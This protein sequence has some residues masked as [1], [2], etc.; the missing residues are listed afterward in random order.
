MKITWKLLFNLYYIICLG[1]SVVIGLGLLFF[2]M[3]DYHF[4]FQWIPAFFALF[5]FIGC[6]LLILIA[7][8]MGHWLAQSEG[9]YEK[10]RRR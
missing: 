10:R 7:K 6:T 3:L 9:Y 5:G 8:G 4:S 2:H 1:G